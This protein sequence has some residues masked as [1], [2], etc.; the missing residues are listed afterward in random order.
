MQRPLLLHLLSTANKE[1]FHFHWDNVGY[2][3]RVPFSGCGPGLLVE[4]AFVMHSI[5]RCKMQSPLRSAVIVLGDT[6]G[7]GGVSFATQT[8]ED[9]SPAPDIVSQDNGTKPDLRHYFHTFA[10][11]IIK[12]IPPKSEPVLH[13]S[14]WRGRLYNVFST[15]CEKLDRHEGQL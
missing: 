15:L 2:R 3:G 14:F 7:C 1:Y 11:L 4:I 5:I 12:R 9:T 10:E 8:E 13:D 6:V